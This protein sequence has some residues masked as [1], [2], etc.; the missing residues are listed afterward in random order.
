MRWSKKDKKS[1]QPS[2]QPASLGVPS[3]IGIVPLGFGLELDSNVG[4]EGALAQFHLTLDRELIWL[5]RQV[6]TMAGVLELHFEKRLEINGLTRRVLQPR[7][8][9][10]RRVRSPSNRYV[11]AYVP[12][13]IT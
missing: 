11:N 7:L 9:D 6:W 12:D 5:M 1:R 3:H 4:P 8:L 2:Q 13:S 10:T